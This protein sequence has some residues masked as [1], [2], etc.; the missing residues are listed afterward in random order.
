ML[1]HMYVLVAGNWLVFT[2]VI[3]LQ[4]QPL[5][6]VA[7]RDYVDVALLLIEYGADI[8]GKSANGEMVP[9]FSCFSVLPALTDNEE[10]C[11]PSSCCLPRGLCASCTC[12]AG[13]RCQSEY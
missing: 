8:D 7:A 9:L 5:H 3:Q 10:T 6:Y 11:V 4:C 13:A 12:V 1:P 2:V